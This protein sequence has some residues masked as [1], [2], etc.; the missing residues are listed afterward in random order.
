MMDSTT[1]PSAV[2]RMTAFPKVSRFLIGMKGVLSPRLVEQILL[3]WCCLPEP[4][5]QTGGYGKCYRKIPTA[6]FKGLADLLKE[7]TSIHKIS[8]QLLIHEDLFLSI[9]ACHSARRAFLP[10]V[11]ESTVSKSEGKPSP[12]RK[13]AHQGG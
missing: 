13:G 12:W 2:R 5:S 4:L 7:V 11:A 8:I 10:G 9:S 6:F 1:P 3:P